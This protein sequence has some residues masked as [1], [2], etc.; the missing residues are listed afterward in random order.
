MLVGW[1]A[2]LINLPFEVDGFWPAFWGAIIV[3]FISWGIN[4]V[5]PDAD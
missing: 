3:G 1:L 5:I 4:L 2:G